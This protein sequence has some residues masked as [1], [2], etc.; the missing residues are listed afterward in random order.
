M[1]KYISWPGLLFKIIADVSDLGSYYLP[2][3]IS[4]NNEYNKHV[5]LLEKYKGEYYEKCQEELPPEES[6]GDRP[7]ENYDV[8][9]PKITLE[10]TFDPETMPEVAVL[11][12]GFPLDAQKLL[13]SFNE[14]VSF[15]DVS[16]SPDLVNEYPILIIP[17]GGLYGLDSLRSF[18]SNLEQYVKDGGILIVFSQQHGYEYGALPGGNLSGFGW[19]EDQSCQHSSVYIDTYHPILSGQDSVTLDV[20]V[21]GYFTKWPEN[22]TVLLSRTKNGM[23]AMLM[24]RY[25][26]GMVIASTIY[27]DWASTHYQ[28]TQDGKNLIRD[29]ITWAKDRTEISEYGRSD[30]VNVSVNVTNV[31]LPIPEVEYPQYEPGDIVDI[32]INVTNHANITSDK[33]SF[34]VFDPDYEMDYVNVS[35]SIPANESR[36]INFTYPTA[37]ESKRGTH[38]VLYSLYTGETIIGGGFGGGFALGVNT[39]NLSSYKVNFTLTDPD[40][41]IVKQENISVYVPPGEI[42]TVNFTYANPSKLGIWHLEYDVFDYNNTFID[43]GTEKFAVSKYAENPEGFVYQGKKITFAVTSPEEHYPYGSEVPFIIHIWNKGDTDRNIRVKTYYQDWSLRRVSL[44]EVDKTLTVTAGGEASYTHILHVGDIYLSHDQ[45]II[46]AE[47]YEDGN[48]LGRTEK[49]V[50]MFRPSVSAHVETD[51]K[52]YAK[53]EDVSVTLNL[54]NKRS[55][56]CN[57][58]V[59][60]RVLD[61]DNK[62]VFEETFNANLS[63]YE[64]LNKT[65]SFILP[66]TAGYGTYIVTA[67]A[68]SNGNRIGSGSAYFEVLKDYMVKVNFD[69]PDKAYRIRENMN[70]DLEVTNI[71]SALWESQINISIPVLAFEDSTFVSLNSNQTETISYNLSISE[72]TP[73]GKH[74]VI[75]TIGFDNSVKKY[76]F[77]IPDSKLILSSEKTSY[78]AGE[79]LSVNLTNIG[80]VDTTC[81][82][83][84]KFYDSR[85]FKI[86]ENNTQESILAGG[87]KTITFKIP[88]QAVSGKYYLLVWCKDMNTN[89]I[90]GLSKS[91]TI[92]GLKA[93]LT[94]V[95]DKKTYFIDENISIFTNIT[96]L[97]GEIV[98]GTLELKIFSRGKGVST[99]IAD[100]AG[101]DFFLVYTDNYD[102]GPGSA[103]F[104]TS[105]VDTSGIVEIPGIGFSQSFTVTANTITTVNIPTS[106]EVQGSDII[107]NK[108]IQ[109]MAEDEVTVYFLNPRVPVYTN[110]AYLGLPVDALGNEYIILAYQETLSACGFSPSLGPSEF[111]IVAPYNNTTITITPS[112]TTSGRTGKVLSSCECGFSPSYNHSEPVISA[113]NNTTSNTPI[114]STI[115]SSRAVGM[116]YTV[117]LDQYQTYTLQSDDALEDLTGTIIES[118]HPI[119]VFAGVRCVD[120]PAG[121]AACDHIVEQMIPTAT[122]GKDFDTFPFMPRLNGL[123]DFLRI[124]ASVDGTVVTI[125]GTTVGTINRGEF[126]EINVSEP[127]EISASEPVLVAQYLTGQEYEGRIGDPFECLIPPTEQFLPKYT[128]ITPTGYA[129]NYVNIIAPTYSLNDLILDGFPVNPSIFTPFGTRGLSAGTIALS[130]GT[131]TM[132]GTAPFGIYVYGYNSYVSYSYPGGLA[133]R[134]LQKELVWQKNITINLLESET[135]NIVTVIS[136]PNELTN[137]TGKLDLIATLFNHINSS[138]VINQSDAHSFFITD[139]NVSLTLETDKEMYKPNEAVKIFGEVQNNA[140]I[141]GGYNFSLEKD[142]VEIF[143]DAFTL[144]PGDVYNFTTYTTSNTSFTLEAMVDGIMVSD[145]VEVETPNVN[146]SVIAPDIVGLSPFDVGILIENIGNIAVDLGVRINSTWNVTIPEGESRLLETTL[147]ITKN[148]TLNVTISGDVNRTI[149]KEIIC[150]ENAKINVT[151]QNL[152]FEGLVEI[153]LTVENTGILDTEFNATFSI[154]DQSITKAFSVPKGQTIN[155][156]L[157]FNLTKGGVMK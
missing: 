71:G 75:V 47:F 3:L 99:E 156:T 89:K 147:N 151:P 134:I 100:S 56:A 95:T 81:N 110:D 63:A 93:A 50:W 24:Y 5:E 7:D 54:T 45:L 19:I 113:Y 46:K 18:K 41:K 27:E 119:A 87:T 30:T 14:P 141:T 138:Q 61:P 60:V 59:N 108:G 121:Y 143:S 73:A 25:G 65:L 145:F 72:T 126:L 101:K 78:N 133:L 97:D 44:E 140:N 42:K 9:T 90:T 85:R 82:C 128:F 13:E 20:V 70:I 131:H 83:S 32:P 33:V 58:S 111:A 52:G 17:T 4:Y 129:E 62:K 6:G 79:Y 1:A 122:W 137:V 57:A 66:I 68:Y 125:N 104:I 118:D 53:G 55:A 123:G 139:K 26:N 36:I 28:S 51:Q 105:D 49:V 142:G 157:S 135:R 154:D 77:V 94:S 8:S 153:P 69:K 74:D 114:T 10:S 34:S 15:V 130:E 67:E 109:L 37:N 64:S 12:K 149:Q 16:F 144:D 152:Y 120:I 96:N 23:P 91:Y 148:T 43:S 84:I 76:Y 155:D 112:I 115:I 116:P 11:F 21:D 106:A 39:T 127:L 117:T 48:N 40:K 150:G 80:G 31:H 92:S 146:V 103:I 136:I 124:L 2:L 88:E 22:A 102:T 107:D 86:Y 98:N 29:I 38:F 132:S 35:A